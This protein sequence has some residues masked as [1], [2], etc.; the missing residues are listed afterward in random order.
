MIYQEKISFDD[1]ITRYQL[2][3]DDVPFEDLD[4]AKE[5]RVFKSIE[6]FIQ[7]ILSKFPNCNITSERIKPRRLRNDKI[8]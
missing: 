3:W 7:F 1:G 4:R 5:N 2:T 6:D 8:H